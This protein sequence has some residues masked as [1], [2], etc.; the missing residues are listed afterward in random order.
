MAYSEGIFHLIALSCTLL[1][2][3]AGMAIWAYFAYARRWYA[4]GC[5]LIVNLL[6]HTLFW[7]TQSSFTE[8]WPL[9]LYRAELIVVLIE[10]SAYRYFLSLRGLT[11]WLLSFSLNLASF[12]AGLWL[13][14]ILL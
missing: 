6:I 14:Q 7:Y 4:I 10:G 1:V 8:L 2:E 11:P 12:L 3:G 5:A 13:W 9:G